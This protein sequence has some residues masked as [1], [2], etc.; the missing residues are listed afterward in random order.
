MSGRAARV[1]RHTPGASCAIKCGWRLHTG[2][3]EQRDGDYF[4]PPLNRAARLLAAGHGGQI[5]LS[6][7]HRGT[8]ARPSAG[9]C[10]AARPGRAPAERPGPPRAHLQVVAPDLPADFPPLKTLDARPNN[11]P[12]QTDAAHRARDASSRG[13][14]TLVQPANVRLLTLTGP[15]APAR[16]AWRC[17]PPPSCSTNSSDGVFFVP[18]AALSDP[19]AG[20]A[21]DRPGAST[22]AKPR[23][24]VARATQGLPARESR[25][26]SCWITS[27]K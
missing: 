20:A 11:L 7:A 10:R 2:T 26:C 18:L 3:A 8:G 9:R 21:S 25:C 19:G 13:Q 4:G 14:R 16:R 24:A 27:S 15:A 17:K 1:E 23:A 6:L 5:L 12:A 22:C